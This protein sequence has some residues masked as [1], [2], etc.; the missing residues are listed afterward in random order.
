MF[1]ITAIVVGR[2]DIAIF[3][4]V[5]E[6][7]GK[8]LRQFGSEDIPM[9]TRVIRHAWMSDPFTLGTYSTPRVPMELADLYRLAAPL[10]SEEEPR[11]LF[12]GEAMEPENWSNLHGA[13]LSGLREARRIAKLL[14][15]S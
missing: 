12:A 15:E 10:P 5:L 4:Q 7:L 3:F 1:S 8:L 14:T 9:P 13:R 11:V 2:K 6:T